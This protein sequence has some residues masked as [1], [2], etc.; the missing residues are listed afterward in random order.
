LPLLSGAK[1]SAASTAT[2]LI[3]PDGISDQTNLMGDGNVASILLDR[4]RTSAF[5]ALDMILSEV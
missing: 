1:R 4:A 5:Y 2:F 3:T